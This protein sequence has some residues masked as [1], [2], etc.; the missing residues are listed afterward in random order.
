MGLEPAKKAPKK[1]RKTSPRP[2]P[3]S[4]RRCDPFHS[5]LHRAKKLANPIRTWVAPGA[6]APAHRARLTR[7]SPSDPRFGR[8]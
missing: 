5:G 4:P 3:N 8:D 2:S 6:N 7:A 1:T